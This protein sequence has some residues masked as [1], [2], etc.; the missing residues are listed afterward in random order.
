MLEN[1]YVLLF[2]SSLEIS[3]DDISI[4]KRTH[5]FR[6]NWEDNYK[7]VWIP[8][9]EQWTDGLRKKF[10]MLRSKMPLYVVQYFLPVARIKFIKEEWHFEYKPIVVVIDEQGNV[11]NDNAIDMIRLDG[12]FIR[13][14]YPTGPPRGEYMLL[15]RPPGPLRSKDIFTT[16]NEYAYTYLVPI[17]TLAHIHA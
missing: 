15:Q 11:I 14:A 6:G 13:R 7:I 1:K 3:N 10:E 5:D 2:I 16:L 17:D 8:I 12:T 4:L 9:V